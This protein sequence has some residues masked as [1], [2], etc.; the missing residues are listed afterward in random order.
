L[1]AALA[2]RRVLETYSAGVKLALVARG[3]ADLYL[4][5]YPQ[6]ND[7]DICAGQILVEEA[8]GRVSGLLGEPIQYGGATG[9]RSGLLA[10]NG[11]LHESAVAAIRSAKT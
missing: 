3:E 1:V 6:F 5:T 9:Q 2:P 10:S 7:W 4:N 8:G 11:L